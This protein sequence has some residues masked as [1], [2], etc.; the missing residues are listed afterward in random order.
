MNEGHRKLGQA[1]RQFFCI[2]Y[3]GLERGFLRGGC[4]RRQI[5]RQGKEVTL[6]VS[7]RIRA[8]L[9]GRADHVH[10]PARLH[11]LADKGIQPRAV[12]FIHHIGVHALAAGG[13]FVD[14]GDVKISVHDQRQSAGDGRGAHHKEVGVAVFL[15]QRGALINTEAVLLIRHH[16]ARY[17]KADALG[18]E[19][20]GANDHVQA[21]GGVVR[22]ESGVDLALL[23]GG[24][25]P[26]QEGAANAQRCKEREKIRG[27]LRRKDPRGGHEGGLAAGLDRNVHSRG[28]AHGLTA[29]HVS[30]QHA[31]HGHV[32]GHVT[33]DIRN[34]TRLRPRKGI[35]Q[36][37]KK[38]IH[39]GLI[40]RQGRC[41]RDASGT[42]RHAH[43]ESKAEKLIK[44]QPPLG[45]M[46]RGIVSRRVDLMQ[47]IAQGAERLC[48][49]Q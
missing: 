12:G 3:G 18:E 10:L 1:G 25:M 23:R 36:G 47:G 2:L 15:G 22:R 8:L 7:R 32:G 21:S 29:P 26:R 49:A 14:A 33:S 45:V 38:I 17:S 35:G 11:L 5:R 4:A 37:G 9:H 19:R 43:A 20:L 40:H 41:A 42:P 46:K 31:V 13:H 6:P 30:D 27:V 34:R 28:G 48:S 39:G 24:G 44:G 16:Q